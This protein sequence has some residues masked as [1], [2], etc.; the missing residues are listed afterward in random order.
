MCDTAGACN[1][2]VLVI[3]CS[4]LM[5][6]KI[7]AVGGDAQIASPLSIGDCVG[8]MIITWEILS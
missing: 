3:C 5:S 1:S 4:V 2:V 6:N 8:D 7:I